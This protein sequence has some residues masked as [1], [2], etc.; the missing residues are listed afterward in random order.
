MHLVVEP[1]TFVAAAVFKVIDSKTFSLALLHLSYI[2]GTRFI[3]NRTI[4]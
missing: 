1:L 4:Y 3:L 2:L